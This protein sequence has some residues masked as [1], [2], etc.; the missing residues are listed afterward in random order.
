M[1]RPIVYTL[2]PSLSFSIIGQFFTFTQS[3]TKTHRMRTFDWDNI[4]KN[5]LLS[6]TV[7]NAKDNNDDVQ[8]FNTGIYSAWHRA[9]DRQQRYELVDIALL[10]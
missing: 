9:A 7:I 6:S 1:S 2:R 5:V 3:F 4:L 10:Q 8:P